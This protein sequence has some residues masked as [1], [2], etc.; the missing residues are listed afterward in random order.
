[1]RSKYAPLGERLARESGDRLRLTFAE[2]EHAL[3]FPLPA[4]ARTHAPWWANV[5]GS[6]VQAKAWMEAGWRTRDV[7]V[8]GQRVTFERV[9]ASEAARGVEEPGAAFVRSELSIDTSQFSQRAARALELYLRDAD[10][11]ASRAIGA[12]LEDAM[13]QRRR[14]LVEWFREH[15]PNV[16]GDST[17]IIREAR[18]A[19]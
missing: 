1:M 8:P 19:R 10:G 18:D 5:G 4:S 15:A 7:D 17:E 3:G 12:A 9:A 13:L 6:H 16:P 14:R 2:V 11:D